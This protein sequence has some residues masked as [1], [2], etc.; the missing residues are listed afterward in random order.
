[1]R[2][3]KNSFTTWEMRRGL[4]PKCISQ[5]FM[6]SLLGKCWSAICQCFFMSLVRVPEVF[7]KVN[8]AQIPSPFKVGSCREVF[9]AFH[10]NMYR[11]VLTPLFFFSRLSL[12]HLVV[13]LMYSVNVFFIFLIFASAVLASHSITRW[14]E[15]YNHWFSSVFFFLEITL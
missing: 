13:W 6:G 14:F 8:S 3:K 2:V 4:E 12:L 9:V 5:V 10:I 11:W 15:N 7:A 1:M